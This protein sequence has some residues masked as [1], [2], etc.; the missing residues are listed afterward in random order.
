M[1]SLSLILV[2]AVR[3]KGVGKFNSFDCELLKYCNLSKFIIDE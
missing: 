2:Q 1:H 3:N